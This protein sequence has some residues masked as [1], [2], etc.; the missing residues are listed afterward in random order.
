[1]GGLLAIMMILVLVLVRPVHV[2][3]HI[4]LLGIDWLGS[5]LWGIFML[6][7]TYICVYGNFYD[8]WDAPEICIASALGLTAL[9]V[10]LWRATFLHH[11]Y[12]SFMAMRTRNVICATTIYL[13][14]FTLTGTEHV[15]E[16]SCA[17]NVLGFDSTNAVDLNWYVFAGIL[18][19]VAFTYFTFALRKWRYKTMT[20][21]GFMF[22]VFYLAYFYFTIDYNVEKRMLFIP[23][24][25]RGFGSVVISIIL[26]T[27][28]VQSGLPF[29][30]FPQALTINGF[31][32]A[33]MGATVGPAIIGETLRY[34]AADNFAKLSSAL[35]DFNTSITGMNLPTTISMYIQ[36]TQLQALVVSMKQIYGYLLSGGLICLAI[37]ILSYSPLRPNAIFPKWSTIRRAIRHSVR[38]LLRKG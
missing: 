30:V 12:I 25:C 19:D 8:W 22:A 24:F 23:L 26:L 33:V 5:L 34:F 2:P 13:L 18:A 31:P 37:I 32:G 17:I 16:E 3:L 35:T 15:F 1:M 20:F 14:F 38:T 10:N 29:M 11:P 6:S 27:Y 4:P 7:F 9:S 28:I 36:Q 21:I